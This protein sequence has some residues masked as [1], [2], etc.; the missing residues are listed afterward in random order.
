LGLFLG[1]IQGL[2]EFLPVSSSGHLMLFQH[3]FAMPEDMLL[4]NII[5]HLAT[6]TAVLVVFRKKIWALA[7][8][9][10]NKTN[11]C[12]LLSTVITCAFVVLFKDFI[13]RTF[14]YKI[15][16]ITFMLTAIILFAT[17]FVRGR[18]RQHPQPLGRGVGYPAAAAVGFTQFLAVVPGLSRSGTTISTLLFAGVERQAAAEYSFLMSIPIIIASFVY[19][20][21]GAGGTVAIDIVPTAAAFIAALGAGILAIRFMLALIRRVKLHWFSLYLVVLAVVCLLFQGTY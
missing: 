14:T 16:P 10:F 13:D 7:R 12:L 9:P 19:E 20:I 8:R 3:L 5:L 18:S 15:L 21:M 1:I 11:L 17:T 4:F 6:L 2:T